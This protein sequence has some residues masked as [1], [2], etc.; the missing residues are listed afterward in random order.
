MSAEIIDEG[1]ADEIA[2]RLFQ[3]AG[4]GADAM[5]RVPSSDHFVYSAGDLIA[6]VYRPERNCFERE[7][8]ALRS[9]DG[10]LTVETPSIVAAGRTDDVDHIVMTRV[11]G[12]SLDRP[13]FYELDEQDRFSIVE[14]LAQL[15]HEIH[16]ATNESAEDDWGEFVEDRWATF[17]QRQIEHGVSDTIIGQLP[18]FLEENLP[19]VPLQPTVFLHGDLHFGNLRFNR[20][21]EKVS[22]S[23]VFDLAD[24]R[25]GFHEY[26]ILAIG[27]LMIQGDREL[28]RRFLNA[29]GFQNSELNKDL[30]RRLMMLTM[31]YETSDLRRYAMRLDASAVDLDLYALMRTIWNFV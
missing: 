26:D 2:R 21:G 12:E 3:S 25:V 10:R 24:S 15:L 28:Q 1:K 8:N 4:V 22:V 18:K 30:Q 31:L 11:G 20:S 17:I 29:Y 13:R 5:Q 19:N 23:G 16:G 6:K 14:G 9:L 7:S 27:L